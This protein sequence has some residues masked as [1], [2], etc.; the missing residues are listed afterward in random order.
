MR[1]SQ[2]LVRRVDDPAGRRP[3]LR[4]DELAPDEALPRER[5]LQALVGLQGAGVV[6]VGLLGEGAEV[7]A[8]QTGL[9]I[10]WVNVLLAVPKQG[11]KRR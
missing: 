11:H 9:R 3:R 10:D 4:L 1:P 7:V 8:V 2:A 5:H 6:R